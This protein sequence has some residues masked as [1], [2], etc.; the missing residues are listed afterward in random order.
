M[1]N[2]IKNLIDELKRRRVFRV[3]TVYAGTAFIIF[4]IIDAT[5]ETLGIPTWVGKYSILLL[6]LGFPVAT[7]LA[8]AFDI[9]EKGVVR[10]KDKPPELESRKPFIGNTSLSIVLAIAVI[11]AVWGWMRPQGNEEST[12]DAIAVLPLDNYMG[13]SSQDYF[14]DG[15]TEAIIAELAKLND[16]RV[17]SRTSA[18]RF[19]DSQKSIPEIAEALGVDVIVE[20]S[21]L[22]AD[23]TVRITAQL[24]DG[25]SDEHIWAKT[26]DK[27]L[28][29]ILSL[30]RE[31]ATAIAAEIKISIQPEAEE[32]I[33]ET[34]EINSEA[35]QLYLKG[36]H[37]RLKET[38][39]GLTRAYNLF[40]EAL[41]IDSSFALAYAGKYIVLLL[42]AGTDIQDRNS[43]LALAARKA[44]ELGP[45]L[46]EAHRTMALYQQFQELNF[47][48]TEA[49]FKRAMEINAGDTELRREYGLFLIRMGRFDEA[50]PHLEFCY[51][52]DPYS[53]LVLRDMGGVNLRSE[54]PH[55]ALEQ[56]QMSL[57]INP[58]DVRAEVLLGLA[59][60]AV[61][62]PEDAF[63]Q[64]EMLRNK[65]PRTFFEGD[66]IAD[67]RSGRRHRLD[68]ALDAYVE[69]MGA[70]NLGNYAK[71]AIANLRGEL[72]TAL[73]YI[74]EYA[75]EKDPG[76][77]S[78]REITLFDNLYEHPGFRELQIELGYPDIPYETFNAMLIRKYGPPPNEISN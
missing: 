3:A 66:W 17:I 11:L 70:N 21:V 64:Y 68:Q 42:G 75:A 58:D 9:T 25:R 43:E 29:Q 71:A 35:Y 56:I 69:R 40:E 65:Y 31:V 37:Y 38:P 60:L 51:A 48:A 23:N 36:W 33:F 2:Q 8:W 27:T 76:L 6:I 24:I 28:S 78:F 34:P 49:S 46:M 4:Q 32:I 41:S 77:A 22:R 15:M 47:Q 39:E 67:I 55:I 7:G 20:G 72:D 59:F 16:L 10:T 73:V 12:Y 62:R 52:Q 54:S 1:A 44:V 19:R 14:V 13:D 53:P 18:M 57:E 50:R 63:Q 30:Q 5:F 26:F 61:N 45:D 74:Q